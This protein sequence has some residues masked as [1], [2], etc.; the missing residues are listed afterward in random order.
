MNTCF[1]NPSNSQFTGPL[2]K[3]Y[4]WSSY[5][6]IHK[7]CFDYMFHFFIFSVYN[8]IS[9]YHSIIYISA[10]IKFFGNIYTLGNI[11]SSQILCEYLSKQVKIFK[12]IGL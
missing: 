3:M 6:V 9:R 4:L 5:V 12:M 8:P 7:T 1:N 2:H 11:V 10:N